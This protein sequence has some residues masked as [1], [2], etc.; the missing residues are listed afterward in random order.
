MKPFVDADIG[1]RLIFGTRTDPQRAALQASRRGPKSLKAAAPQLRSGL[2]TEI[3]IAVAPLTLRSLEGR[4]T[5][6][7]KRLGSPS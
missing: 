4:L 3:K 1:H 2:T 6:A 7:G 5:E